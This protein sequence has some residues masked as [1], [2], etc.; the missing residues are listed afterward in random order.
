MFNRHQ[1]NESVRDRGFLAGN[2]NSSGKAAM[3]RLGNRS[4][5]ILKTSA[6]RVR[7]VLPENVFGAS[8]SII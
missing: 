3:K 6:S 7:L 2:E 1:E 5:K 8:K 4:D